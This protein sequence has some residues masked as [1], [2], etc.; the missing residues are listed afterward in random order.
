MFKDDLKILDLQFLSSGDPIFD[1]GII[2]LFN[3]NENY[4]A[5]PASLDHLLKIY[6]TTFNDK[7]VQLGCGSSK[8][9]FENIQRR[10]TSQYRSIFFFMTIQNVFRFYKDGVRGAILFGLLNY[11][12]MIIY[13]KLIER[14]NNLS[15]LMPEMM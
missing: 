1:L 12:I 6:Q 2:V 15:G 4:G 9:T 11:D 10:L 5:E 13:E 7:L 8:E 14:F 3:S